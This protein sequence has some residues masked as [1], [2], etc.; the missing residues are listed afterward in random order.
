MATQ[1]LELI[2]KKFPEYMQRVE[3]NYKRNFILLAF[4]TAFFTFSTSLLSQDTVLPAFLSNLTDNLVLIGLIPAIFNLGYFLP[5][6]ISA[7]ITQNTPKRKGY[8]LFIAIAERVGILF[9]AISA[10]M[11]GVLPDKFVIPFF[12]ISFA[13]YAS[14]FGLI[15]PAYSDFI[16]KAIYKKRGLYFGVNQVLGGMIGFFASIVTA[17]IL[18]TSNFPF[19]FRLLFWISFSASFISPILIANFKETEF[20]IQPSKKNVR[21]FTKHIIQVIRGNANLRN[22][23]FTRQLIGLAAMGFSF[24]AI[25]TIK[26][27]DLPLS[28][29][30]IYTMIIIISQSL[31]GVLWGY[32]GDK[33]GYKK[34]M[35]LSTVF[36][37]LQGIIALTIHHPSGM[38]AISITIGSVYSAMYICHP[39]LIFE[40]APPEETSLFIGLSNSLIAP[41]IGTAPILAGAIVDNLGYTQL[42]ITISVAAIAAFVLAVFV[43]VEPR[44]FELDPAQK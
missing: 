24:Y 4:D 7:F 26:S 36:L 2:A 35:V 33:F 37:L 27:Y 25:Y 20:P 18:E 9:I 19:N 3:K 31:S 39:N 1:D 15:M 6:I 23:I 42:F 40:I 29:L 44:K 16:S 13:V 21:A 34:V 38:L 14:T 30:G 43:F 32:I 12:L 41:I 28:T 10:Q 11:S 17:R 8:I 22:Y 5:Q